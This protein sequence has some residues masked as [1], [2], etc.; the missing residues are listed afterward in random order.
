MACSWGT[1][2]AASFSS[3]SLPPRPGGPTDEVAA[4]LHSQVVEGRR[5]AGDHARVQQQQQDPLHNRHLQQQQQPSG[6]AWPSSHPQQRRPHSSSPLCAQQQ[7]PQQQQAC[8]QQHMQAVPLPGQQQLG[9]SSS[10]GS[11]AHAREVGGSWGS[12]GASRSL[13][14]GLGC[15]Q[16]A[17]FSLGKL[18]AGLAK[19]PS[20]LSLSLQ[21]A[22]GGGQKGPPS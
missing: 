5:D 20:Q 8:G 15:E 19:V 1:T 9:S 16:D 17:R 22:S 10:T 18:T 21:L 13:G 7:P 2:Q 6:R 12:G 3:S 14:S 11:S 4:G